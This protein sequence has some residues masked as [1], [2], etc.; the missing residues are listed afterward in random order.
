LET[1]DRWEWAIGLGCVLESPLLRGTNVTITSAGCQ[2]KFIHSTVLC[3]DLIIW[4]LLVTKYKKK[5]KN[6]IL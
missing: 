4:Q 1:P 2:K 5:S 6:K 3:V